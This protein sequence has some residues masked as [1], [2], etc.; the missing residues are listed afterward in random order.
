MIQLNVNAVARQFNG[1]PDMPLLW[2]LRD[3]LQLTGTK[4]GCG[5]GS[6]APARCTSMATPSAA[7]LTPMNNAAGKAVV[8]IEGLSARWRSSRAAGLDEMN[9]PQCG[10]CQSGQI[11]QAAALLKEKPK[12]TDAG[13]RR[14]HAGQYLPL[15]NVPTHPRA[16]KTGRGGE[17]MKHTSATSSAAAVFL[18]R[19]VLGRRLSCARGSL[20]VERARGAS[21]PATVTAPLVIP[22]STWASSRRQR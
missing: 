11:M 21:E 1:D 5:M 7:A 10:Y 18:E 15:R 20:P 4:F 12:P 3:V 2:Y 9:V 22:A 19:I 17:S 16:I 8:T 13:Y 14:R 6:A